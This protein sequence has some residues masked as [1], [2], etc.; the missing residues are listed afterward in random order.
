M[1]GSIVSLFQSI[2]RRIQ[3]FLRSTAHRLFGA[4]DAATVFFRGTS[5][6]FAGSPTLQEIGVTPVSTDPVVATIFATEAENYGK[7]VVHITSRRDLAGVEMLKGNVLAHLERE[8]G[9]N[10]LPAE[11]A[12]RASATITASQARDIL[13]RI[14]INVQSSIRGAAAVDA[15]L[16]ATPRL[17]TEQI[18]QF[19]NAALNLGR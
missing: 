9:L 3:N 19:L 18:Q 10:I 13:A 4:T 14:G 2:L 5:E 17:A 1:A 6:G 8:V 16:R 15:V 11:F 12:R 7:G